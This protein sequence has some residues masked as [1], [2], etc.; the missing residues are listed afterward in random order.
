MEESDLYWILWK[1][2]FDVK[3]QDILMQNNKEKENWKVFTEKWNC[4]LYSRQSLEGNYKGFPGS[5]LQEVV[6]VDKFK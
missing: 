6:T 3:R 5:V 2:L 1:E 4:W